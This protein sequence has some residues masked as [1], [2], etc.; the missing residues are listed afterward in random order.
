MQTTGKK[1]AKASGSAPKQYPKVGN[2]K[3][4]NWKRA[5]SSGGKGVNK[6]G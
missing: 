6:R 3:G 5:N 4:L 2:G 1:L